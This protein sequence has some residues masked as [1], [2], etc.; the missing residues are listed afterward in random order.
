MI[1]ENTIIAFSPT[2]SGLYCDDSFGE[3]TQHLACCDVFG[4]AGGDWVGCIEEQSTT[5][6]NLAADPL[7]CNAERGDLRLQPVSPCASH[8]ECG[9]LGA[10][11]LGCD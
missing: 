7:F 2:G 8:S 3:C 4:N 10:M 6:G 11:P 1:L 5:A 9:T